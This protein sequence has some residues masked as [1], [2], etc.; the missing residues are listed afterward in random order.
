MS[1]PA[2]DLDPA[3]ADGLDRWHLIGAEVH[4]LRARAEGLRGPR[5]G[6]RA[7]VL[8]LRASDLEAELLST[9]GV[10][11]GAAILRVMEEHP[12][13][14]AAV[15]RWQYAQL[16]AERITTGDLSGGEGSAAEA[17]PP[18]PGG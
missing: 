10:E 1:E 7:L 5:R 4:V 17:N 11:S 8:A 13:T 15:E 12:A 9:I 16:L 2:V 18:E 14:L 6:E 3:L